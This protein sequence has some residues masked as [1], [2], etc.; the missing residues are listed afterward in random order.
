MNRMDLRSR[1]IAFAAHLRDPEHHP[2]PDDVEDRR[3]QVYRDLFFNNV[4]GLLA[5]TFPVLHEILGAPRWHRLVRGFFRDHRCH[6]PLFLEVPGEF[7]GYLRDARPPAPDDPPFM[8]E[9]AHYEWIELAQN[10]DP[11]E[12]DLTGIDRTADLLEG[13]PVLS[14]LAIPLAYRFPVHR[15]SPQYQPASP[16]EQPS[17]YVVYRDLEDKVGFLEINALTARLLELIEARPTLAGQHHV[18][19]LVLDLAR[20]GVGDLLD[21]ARDA[22]EELRHHDVILGARAP[23]K[24]CDDVLSDTTAR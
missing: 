13:V 24:A 16:P 2:A 4:S 23:R 15:L 9:L 22:L 6:T 19:Q 12:I 5:G 10:V 11:Q 3:M 8:L 14:P 1:Q 21:H 7:L 17:F 18:E 20:G